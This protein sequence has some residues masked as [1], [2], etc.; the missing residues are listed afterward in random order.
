MVSFK[1]SNNTQRVL[2]WWEIGNLDGQFEMSRRGLIFISK[3]IPSEMQ[4]AMK[5]FQ[6]QNPTWRNPES[7]VTL[8]S[9]VHEIPS[10]P[11]SITVQ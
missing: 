3:H 11:Q 2:Q 8:G 1:L 7:P 5:V 4:V 9:L 10:Q 6:V